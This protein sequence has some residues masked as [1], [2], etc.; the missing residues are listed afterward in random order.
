MK[1][2]SPGEI[3]DVLDKMGISEKEQKLNLYLLFGGMI[4]YYRLFEKYG[5]TDLDSAFKNLVFDEFGPL[6]NEVRDVLVEEFGRLHPTYYE[7]ISALARGKATQ[8]EIADLT[9]IAPGSLPVYLDN[10]INLL[11]IVEYRIPATEDPVRSKKGRY[12]LKDNFFRF[13]AGFIYPNMSRFIAGNEGDHLR[14]EVHK[15]WQ[16]Y[17]GLLFE[18]LVRTLLSNRF[19]G[20]YEKTGGWWNRR[21]DEIDFIAIGGGETPLAIEVKN[22]EMSAKDAGLILKKLSVKVKMIPGFYGDVKLGIVSKEITE[23]DRFILKED[24]YFVEDIFRLIKRYG[25]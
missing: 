15:E 5:C 9:H 10:L 6:R 25:L 8:K 22:R 20:I 23:S 11:G 13:Y 19:L 4:Y 17:S 12:F 3:W 18:D 14:R 24:G 2:F 7:I 16:S 21:G 1:P